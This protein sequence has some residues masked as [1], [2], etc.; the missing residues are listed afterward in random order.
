MSYLV[1]GFATAIFKWN[2]EIIASG[3]HMIDHFRQFLRWICMIEDTT[4]H[5][6]HGLADIVSSSM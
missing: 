4:G 6:Y 5:N 1:I 2:F 3:L